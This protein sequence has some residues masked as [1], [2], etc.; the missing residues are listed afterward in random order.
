M[1]K[2]NIIF[3]HTH[4]TSRYVQPYG[5]AIPAPNLQRL[6]E[7]GVLFRNAFAAAPTCSPSRASFLTGQ[8]PHCCGM[9]GLGHRGFGMADNSHHIV[10][11]L[12]SAGYRTVHG[13]ID[14]TVPH[15]SGTAPYEGYDE[16]IAAE[17]SA[18]ENLG[19]AV[20]RFLEAGPQ[21]PFFMAIG[22]RETHRPYSPAEP[23][24]F[25][26]ED[27]RYC[28]PPRPLPDTPVIRKDFANFKASVRVMDTCYGAIFEA[29]DRAGLAENTLVCC[30]TDHGLEF[31]LNMCNLTDHGIGVYLVIRGPG[32]F[33][34]GK[35][36]EAMV[37]L[38]D[39]VPTAYDLAGVPRPAWVDGKSLLPLMAGS[40][41]RVHDEIFAEITYHAAY[42]P[43]RCV[44]TERYRYIR[45]FDERDKLVLPNADDT[46]SKEEMLARGWLDQPRD[47]EMLYDLSFDPDEVNNLVGRP[48][49]AGVL[50]EMRE[51]LDRYMQET[52]DPLL[53][54]PVPAPIGAK[55]ND[56]NGRSPREEPLV[57]T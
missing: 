44:R 30:F 53:H 18:A 7:E 35:V 52:G 40:V 10:H 23:E 41:D 8:Y 48:D 17:N 22:L 56:P 38:V 5:H 6:A 28:T 27:W 39:L 51:R 13:G 33:R 36:E 45:R 16:V 49:M 55:F 19:P 37:S 29:L 2:P 32:G 57:A 20:V 54:G 25:P 43:T 3:L 42:E 21:E 46:P 12:S 31:P 26:A 11:A 9:L 34:G 15:Q 4:N 24:K 47:Q 14:H 1:S 50:A